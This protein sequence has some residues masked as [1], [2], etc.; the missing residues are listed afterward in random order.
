MNEADPPA[1]DRRLDAEFL[2]RRALAPED[3]QS[4]PY[5]AALGDALS[6][7]PVA[8]SLL[9]DVP[10]EDR[11]PILIFAILHYLALR[12]HPV[13]APLY[14]SLGAA[15]SVTPNE[16]ATRVVA[17]VETESDAVRAQLHRRTQTNEVGRSAVLRA[18]MADLRAGGLEHTSI[19]D[20][21]TSAGLNLYF[22]Q[23]A[24]SSSPS[25]DPLTI[26]TEFIDE[27][28]LLSPLPMITARVGLDRNPLDLSV[29]DDALWLRACLWPE[30]PERLARFDAILARRAQWP[31][32]TL[33]TGDAFDALDLAI[34]RCGK[35]PLVIIHTWV[36][37]Y[38]PEALQRAF[39][40]KVRTL[41][42]DG[43]AHW[44]Y[45]EWPPMVPGLVPPTPSVPA[46]RPGA[47]QV[48]LARAGQEPEHWGWCHSHG[49]WISASGPK[50]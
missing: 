38:F 26:T 9:L 18:V 35:G 30:A 19:L 13:L 8:R 42:R 24:V 28:P 34:E 17:V 27:P 48:V 44:I 43:R 46:P 10:I 37:A 16:F 31:P 40:E 50:G 41:V 1:P 25:E 49:R 4:H 33:V 47:S 36:A 6:E 3:A 2:F 14:R 11:N 22:D 32:V 23:F 20:V 7:N 29:D 15:P 12:G 39:G 21:G 5:Y 45:A